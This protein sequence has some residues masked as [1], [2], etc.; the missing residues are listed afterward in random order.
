MADRF[1]LRP[2]CLLLCLLGWALSGAAATPQRIISLTP[3]LTELLYDIGAGD[4]IVATDD[5]SDFPPEVAPLP[6]VAN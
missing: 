4:R 5:A 3:H 1:P 6:R 2:L